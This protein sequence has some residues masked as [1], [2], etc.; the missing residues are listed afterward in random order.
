VETTFGFVMPDV[1][2]GGGVGVQYTPS[3]DP[4]SI[5]SLMAAMAAGLKSACDRYGLVCPRVAVEPGRSLVATAGVTLYQV[6]TQKI[7]PDVRHYVAV[8][9]GMG[10]NIRPALYQAQYEAV[11]A[12]RMNEAHDHAVS[13]VGKYCES[14]DV[15]IREC[16]VPAAIDAGDILMVFTT[17]AYNASMASTYNRIPRPATVLVRDGKATVLV[18]RETCDD[19]MR[20][21]H[22]LD[23]AFLAPVTPVV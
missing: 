9:G 10:D 15:V 18:A 3:D 1:D 11:V 19:L 23:A 13:V 5:V 17:G 6:G 8:D 7:I 16:L 20:L 22:W 14:G 12:N 2:L 21:D 4:P